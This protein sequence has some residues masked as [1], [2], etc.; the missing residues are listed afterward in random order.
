MSILHLQHTL[1]LHVCA[2]AAR[3]KTQERQENKN[4]HC[5]RTSPTLFI[6]NMYKKSVATKAFKEGN[7]VL[8]PGTELNLQLIQI[9]PKQKHFLLLYM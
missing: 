7:D 3:L 5:T 2:S 8:A 6:T 4:L 1:I 9:K